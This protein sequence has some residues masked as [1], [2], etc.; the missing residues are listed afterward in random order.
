M[1]FPLPSHFY[2]DERITL[3]VRH[4][5]AEGRKEAMDAAAEGEKEEVSTL[6]SLQSLPPEPDGCLFLH[7]IR[8][9]FCSRCRFG[10]KLIFRH[11]QFQ[12]FAELTCVCVC[13]NSQRKAT[14]LFVDL[15]FLSYC[16]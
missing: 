2:A 6:P 1:M 10:S 3:M 4:L 12:L 5:L 9:C 11:K 7:E 8:R 16:R 15:Y 14:P 13:V